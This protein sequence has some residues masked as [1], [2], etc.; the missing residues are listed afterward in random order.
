MPVYKE[1]SMEKLTRDRLYSLEQY[2]AIRNDF[3]SRVV[4]HK[5]SRQLGVGPNARL[6]F[7]DTLTVQYQVQEMLRVER[8]FESRGI[9][10][11]IATYNPLIPDGRNWKATFMLEY[12]DV[13]ERRVM[14]QKL[15]GVEDR[16]WIRV[17]DRD[18]VFAIADEDLERENDEKTSSVHFLRFELTDEMAADVKQGRGILVGIEHP[19]YRY[20]T[21]VPPEVRESLKNDLD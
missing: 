19:D 15:I 7:E 20:Q 3:R 13:D 18:R 16:V 21:Q 17:G 6:Y 2:A 14:L 1:E 11:E 12:H 8:I 10:E 5:K 4:Q 9:E